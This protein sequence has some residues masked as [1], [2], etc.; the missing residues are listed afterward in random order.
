MPVT[1][2]DAALARNTAMPARSAGVAPA[3]GRGARRHALVQPRHLRRARRVSSVS[4]QPGSTALTWMLSVAHAVA[5]ARVSCTMPPL[6]D[7]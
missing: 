6:L 7:A 1:K 3:A 2:S 4:I 5:I